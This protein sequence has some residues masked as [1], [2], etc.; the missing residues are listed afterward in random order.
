MSPGT[1]VLNMAGSGPNRSADRVFIAGAEFGFKLGGIGMTEIGEDD[2]SLLP[3]VTGG[4]GLA[5]GGARVA[6]VVQRGSELEN[7]AYFPED[8]DGP[9]E[10][11]DGLGMM[12]E[13]M[14]NVAEAVPYI[15]LRRAIAEAT[16][17]F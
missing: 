8:A 15:G 16:Q 12:I 13:T 1:P 2:E 5:E 17:Q 14:V 4:D 7:V 6:E 9:L 11:V 3:G 10:A